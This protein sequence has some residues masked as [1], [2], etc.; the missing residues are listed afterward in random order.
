MF[1]RFNEHVRRSLFFA[2]YEASRAGSGVIASEHLLLGMLREIIGFGTLLAQADLM[3]GEGAK[4]LKITLADD[5]GGFLLAILPPGAFIGLGL[6]IAV[7]NIIDKR[8]QS[9]TQLQR[10]PAGDTVHAA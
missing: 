1:E 3:F 7:K 6:L 8:M 10:E 4:A 5:Y 9:R 2:R